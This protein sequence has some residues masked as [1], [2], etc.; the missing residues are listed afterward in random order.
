ML[1]PCCWP[2]DLSCSSNP[3]HKDCGTAPVM[4]NRKQRSM[5]LALAVMTL[6]ASSCS[7]YVVVPLFGRVVAVCKVIPVH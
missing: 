7:M 4:F 3:M 1:N 2:N 5:L 6:T